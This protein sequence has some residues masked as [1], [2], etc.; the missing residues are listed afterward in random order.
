M[1]AKRT[2]RRLGQRSVLQQLPVQSRPSNISGKTA[3]HRNQPLHRPV[4]REYDRILNV[5]GHLNKLRGAQNAWWTKAWFTP[6]NSQS[7]VQPIFSKMW[8]AEGCWGFMIIV[9]CLCPP[10]HLLLRL[11]AWPGLAR[12]WP[13]I[14]SRRQTKREQP[15]CPC[16]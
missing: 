13:L 7:E 15:L 5:W 2:E 8:G 6:K 11:L 16:W 9:L 14:C 4:R 12:P 10:P 3:A 1:M